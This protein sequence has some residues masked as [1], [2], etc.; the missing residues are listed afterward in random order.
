[1]QNTLGFGN[2]KEGEIAHVTYYCCV[3]IFRRSK[4]I[5]EGIKNI[6]DSELLD[7]CF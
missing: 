3:H 2:C 5:T 7:L 4:K 6:V 1:M